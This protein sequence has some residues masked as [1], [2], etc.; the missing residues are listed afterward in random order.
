MNVFACR[1]G[2]GQEFGLI[3][4]VMEL[5]HDPPPHRDCE[6]RRIRTSHRIS[7]TDVS[8]RLLRRSPALRSFPRCLPPVRARTRA[9][10]GAGRGGQPLRLAHL[11]PPPLDKATQVTGP[12]AK[13][14][15][16]DHTWPKCWQKTGRGRPGRHPA[17]QRPLRRSG[18]VLDAEAA[19]KRKRPLAETSSSSAA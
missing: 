14:A 15:S 10:R 3:T 16:D 17:E 19:R 12:R 6:R 8:D 18:P 1:Q 5:G 13:A 9:G 4:V 11:L 2:D 7:T